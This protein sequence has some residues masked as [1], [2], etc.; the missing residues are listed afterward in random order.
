MN[1][2]KAFKVITSA[3]ALI[4]CCI[5]NPMPTEAS[6]CEKDFWELVG[7]QSHSNSLVKMTSELSVSDA[8]VGAEKIGQSY[9]IN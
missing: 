1:Q 9:S 5:G 7:R 3:A 6:T 4:T 8:K 2:M